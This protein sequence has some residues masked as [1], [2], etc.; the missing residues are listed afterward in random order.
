MRCASGS[1]CCPMIPLTTWWTSAVKGQRGR[2]FFCADGLKLKWQ[3]A[4]TLCELVPAMGSFSERD[5]CGLVCSGL[6]S[7][8]AVRGV[9]EALL[10]PLVWALHPR[11]TPGT[12]N[13]SLHGKAC[14]APLISARPH[15]VRNGVGISRRSRI[16]R[17]RVMIG[18]F[19]IA[20]VVVL[21]AFG[22]FDLLSRF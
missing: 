2:G 20:L 6:C 14:D 12:V 15:I 4:P 13:F 16:R 5:H 7:L 10:N 22:A 19:G 1:V 3:I 17:G 11:T 18:D 8:F 21:F 9:F